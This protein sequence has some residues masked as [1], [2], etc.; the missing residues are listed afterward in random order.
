MG[1]MPNYENSWVVEDALDKAKQAYKKLSDIESKVDTI[2]TQISSPYNFKGNVSKV[3]DLPTGA[4][5]NDT[6]YVTGEGDTSGNPVK[7]KYTWNGS[8]WYQ[9]SATADDLPDGIESSITSLKE[10][11]NKLSTGDIKDLLNW[12]NSYINTSGVEVA[13]GTYKTSEP[14]HVAKDEILFIDGYLASSSVSAISVCDKDGN[15]RY[16]YERGWKDTSH[17]YSVTYYANVDG[18]T[19]VRISNRSE[20]LTIRKEKRSLTEK[21][22]VVDRERNGYVK[23]DGTLVDT[24]NSVYSRTNAF[25]V[26]EGEKIII[27]GSASS[28]VALLT[29]VD[30]D[31]IT[32]KRVI[33]K[34]DDYYNYFVYTPTKA[35]WLV[36][37]SRMRITEPKSESSRIAVPIEDIMTHCVAFS[38]YE[39][40]PLLNKKIQAFG[41]SLVA[42]Y[43]LG[44]EAC[45]VNR[46][47]VDYGAICE[48]YAISGTPL[49][50]P[51]PSYN[52]S[53]N[54]VLDSNI[55]S[56]ADYVVFEGGANDWNENIIIGNVSSE[57]EAEFYGALNKI[58]RVIHT[59]APTATIIALTNYNRFG[60]TRT[61]SVGN[62]DIDYVKAM[63]DIC[64]R[65][66]AKVFNNFTESGFLPQVESLNEWQDEGT[67][68]TGTPNYHI[69]AKMYDKLESLYYKLF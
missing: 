41:D 20:N 13:N 7:C 10:S 24:Y 64:E 44:K 32:T 50:T 18:G 16:M 46:I 60:L 2:S 27:N 9:S 1:K 3:A 68:V 42:A 34:G 8:A 28:G 51:N 19:Y 35:E 49:A 31:T 12:S 26:H 57:D 47:A 23:S 54:R 69:S 25:H 52:T 55:S 29:E 5:V 4:S 40:N 45:W 53:I 15:F 14:I 33:R 65:N 39:N 17:D 48:N 22:Q 37:S 59:K 62:K 67:T 63:I 56:D 43:H 58:M 66:A 21:I 61:N 36:I 38:E 30:Q 11:L 6:Y